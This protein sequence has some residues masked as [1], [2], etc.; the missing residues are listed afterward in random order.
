M[1][2]LRLFRRWVCSGSARLSSSKPRCSP[3]CCPLPSRLLPARP[4]PLLR[5]SDGASPRA[6]GP[7][8]ASRVLVLALALSATE[9]L[10]G[11]VLT[12]FPWN[13]LGYALTY[14]L[15]LMQ[16]AAV[17][18]I[19]GLTLVRRPRLRPAAGA[20]ERGAGRRRRSARCE[21][22][23]LAVA[24]VPLAAMCRCSARLRLALGTPDDRC[25][26]SRSASCSRACRSAR[27]GARRT[28]RASSSTTSTLSAANPAGEADNLAGITHVIWPEAAM[29][30]LPLDYPEARAAI[31]RR[32]AAGTPSSS[33]AHCAPS[34]RRPARRGRGASST[35]SW[36]SARSGSL[37]AR[38]DKIHLVP[39]GEYLPLQ[40]LLEAI[41]LAAAHP[42]ARRL[43]HRRDAAPAAAR[44]AALPLP[45]RSSATRRSSR[46]GRAGRRAAGPAAQRHQRRLVRQHHGAAAALA[47]GPRPRRRGGACRSCARPTTAFRRPSTATGASWRG[48][49]S[50]CAAS[51]DVALPAALAPPPYA[52]LGDLIFLALWLLGRCRGRAVWRERCASGLV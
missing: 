48:S 39:F 21:A 38:Y 23:A 28:R 16:S 6:S 45:R 5:R 20:V 2:R 11:H 8:G 25:L 44:A 49:I 52:R 31:G 24:C 37:T 40:P 12:G 34:R 51:I 17:F 43:R 18:G 41:G 29:P 9:W 33:R 30:F 35:A 10:R 47:P 4:C 13:V 27:S 19:Y 14:P 22:R 15:P 1:V 36:C 42:P 26:A 7:R 46:R 50:T 3:C 32:A